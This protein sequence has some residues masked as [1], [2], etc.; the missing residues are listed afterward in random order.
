M[1]KDISALK[2]E[3]VTIYRENIKRDGADKLLDYMLSDHSDFFTAPASTRFHGAHAGGLRNSPFCKAL[4]HG[5]GK[6]SL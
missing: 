4:L 6:D 3:F 5:D 1:E 2:E